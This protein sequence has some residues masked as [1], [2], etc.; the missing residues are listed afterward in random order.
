MAKNLAVLRAACALGAMLIAGS[1]VNAQERPLTISP[2]APAAGVSP[3]ATFTDRGGTW[4]RVASAEL[5]ATAPQYPEAAG[6]PIRRGTLVPNYVDTAP[7][8][9]VSIR[10]LRR[11]LYY[12]YFGTPEGMTVIVNPSTMRVARMMRGGV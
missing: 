6:V 9:N 3:D 1:A 10:G 8:R 5:Y 11:G 12:V 4:R 7:M 2:R